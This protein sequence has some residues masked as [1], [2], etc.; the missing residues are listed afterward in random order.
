ML[1]KL[2]NAPDTQIRKMRQ[3]YLT[4]FEAEGV[5]RTDIYAQLDNT[6]LRLLNTT[7]GLL[8][9]RDSQI[10]VFKTSTEH[11]ELLSFTMKHPDLRMERIKEVAENYFRFVMLSHRWEA[12]EP[13]LHDIQGNT[14]YKPNPVGGI[15]KLQSF[16][17]IARD[18]GYC[19]AWSDTC[20]IDKTNN[21]ELQESLNSMFV[22]Y[23]HSALTIVYLSDVPPS[24]ESGALSQSAW[25]RR[26]WTVGEF[27]A[28]KVILFYQKNWTRY[29][30]DHSSNH[31]Q[32]TAIMEELGRATGI[33][34]LALVAFRPGMRGAR[35]KL[36]WASTRVTTLQEDTAYSL[37][38]IFGIH[39]PVIYGEKKQNALG[40]LLQEIVAES[41]D[42]TALDWVGKSSEFNSCLPADIT[43]YKAPPSTPPCLSEDNMQKSVSVL[44]R[45]MSVTS[46]S[47]LC[48][49]LNKLSAPRFAHRRLHLP[50]IVFHIT[51][52]RRGSGQGSMYSTYEVKAGGL[53]DL[54]IITEDTLF[55][56]TRGSPP[57]QKLLLVLPWNRDLLDFA[58]DTQSAGGRSV[59]GSSGKNDPQSRPLRLLG[60]LGQPF[61][62][63]LLAQQRSGEYKR[64]ASDRNIIAQVKNIF[65]YCSRMVVETLEIL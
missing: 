47:R 46:A 2:E 45:T 28:P 62:A 5:I 61:T 27:L 16:C 63:F 33:D 30:G 38:G 53:H 44:Q 58:D 50:C 10:S 9:D 43:S 64:I 24:S 25:T 57:Q 15:M 31:K 20:C 35:E 7:T 32:S 59:P 21:F 51:E 22:W 36:Q 56:F 18:A 11:K 4:P 55:E 14:V 39:L 1:S 13:L 37:F 41:G 60:R 48:Q 19:W 49:I 42:I 6:P 3:H 40:R 8:C 34:P 17:K 12:N 65:S 52:L 54:L 29:L 26:G 23:R